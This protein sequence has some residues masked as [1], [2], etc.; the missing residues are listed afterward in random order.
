MN[1]HLQY[2]ITI[3]CA[4]INGQIINSGRNIRFLIYTGMYGRP[5]ENTRNTPSLP[6][7]YPYAHGRGNLK[8]RTTIAD[9]VHKSVVRNVIDKPGD[10]VGM[11]FY[12][13][14]IGLSG[15][16]NPIGSAVII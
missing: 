16:Y 3:F 12:D 1:T 9:D 6:E 8:I 10:L 4:Y 5:A 14:F 2:L 13:N 11:A 7:M 15:I